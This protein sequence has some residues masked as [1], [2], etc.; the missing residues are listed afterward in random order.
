MNDRMRQ[1]VDLLIATVI[2]GTTIFVW[3]LV[4]GPVVALWIAT[5][6]SSMY[7]FS[8]NP[9]GSTRGEA[10]N[11]RIDELYDRYLP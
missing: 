9:W 4:T 8:R 11:E 2:A 6:F 1:F 5:L 3:Q 7:Y 10:Y